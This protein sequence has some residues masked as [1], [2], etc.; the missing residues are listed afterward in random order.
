MLVVV[1]DFKQQVG[2]T[3]LSFTGGQVLDNP[4]LE[5]NLLGSSAPVVL[6]KNRADLI[7][8]PHCARQF[9]VKQAVGEED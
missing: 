2:G 8:C 6:V 4:S 9:T 5:A 1:K 7:R 3:F